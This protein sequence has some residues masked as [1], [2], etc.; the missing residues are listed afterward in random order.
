MYVAITILLS[1]MDDPT[2]VFLA[3][4]NIECL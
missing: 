2:Y 1:A 4:I 3:P